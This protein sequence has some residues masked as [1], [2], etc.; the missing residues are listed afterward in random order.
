MYLQIW[1][2]NQNICCGYSKE[3]SQWDVFL[4]TQNTC[5]HWQ[6]K[7]QLQV[8]ASYSLLLSKKVLVYWY[9]ASFENP[10]HMG[11]NARKPVFGGLPTTQAQTRLCIR[12]DW[13]APLLFAFWKVL[14][15]NLLQAKCHFFW[16]VPV[17]QETGLKLTLSETPKT[18]FLTMR[19]IW[20]G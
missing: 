8:Q 13:S 17:A 16:L 1:F 4:S 3:P 11:V 12:T 5:L 15:L 19:P 2:L 20:F 14:Y 10:H 7:I 6:V 18:G 9:G